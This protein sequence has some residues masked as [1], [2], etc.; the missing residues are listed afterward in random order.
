MNESLLNRILKDHKRRTRS[1]ALILCLSMIVSLG[2]FAGFHQTAIAKVYTRE[3]L[4]CPY[5]HEGAEPVAH[6]HND[7]CY[8]GETLVCTL[9]EREAHT[10]T[11]EC[12]AE[13]RVLVCTLEEN[14]GH[15]HSEACFDENGELTCQ[16]PEGEG[17]HV[18][19]DDC[20]T[21]ERVLTCD[22]PELPVHVHDAGCFRTEEITVDEPEDTAASEQAVSTVPEMPVS[23]PNADIETAEDWNRE[24]ENLEL[25]GNWARDL[26]LVAATQQG[27]GESPNNFE[28][29][30][31]DAGD[32]W[33]RHGYTRYGAW[34]GYPYAEWDAMFVSF[35]LRYAGIPA[36]NVPNNPTAAYMAESFSKGELFAGQDYV[37]AVGDL[38]FFDTADDE[39]T[40]ID[41]MGIV[42]HVDAE[43][44]TINTVEGD[45]TDTVA[46]FGYYLNDE[47][48]VGYGILPQNPNYVPNEEENTD[49]P[50]EEFDGFIFMTTDEEEETPAAEE[51]TAPAVSMPAQSWERTAGGIKVSVEAPEGAFPENTTIAVTPVNGNSLK[52]TVSDAVSG[53]VLE[54]Q[55]VDITFFDA[56]GREIEPAVPIRVVMTP[57]A[58]ENAEEKTSVVH[59]DVAQQTAELIEQAE[60]TEADNSEVVFDADAFTIYAIVYTYQVEYEYEVDGKTFTSSMPGAENMSLTQIV[61]GLGIVDETEIETFVSKIASIASSNEEVAV[62]NENNEIRVLKDGEA[63]IVI[64]MQDGAK[65]H[66][67]VRAEGETSA[68]NETATVSTV[69]E[70]YLPADAELKA[71]VVGGEQA[72]EA[73]KAIEGQDGNYQVFDIS[74]DNVEVD[75]YD[76][77]QVDLTLPAKILGSEFHLYHVHEGKAEELLLKK[78]SHTQDDGNELVESVSFV[79]DSFSYFVLSYTV[80][81]TFEI[82]G[83]T[84]SY[85][86]P[87]TTSATISDILANLGIEN[88]D[89]FTSKISAISF[90][91]P[92]L[93][94]VTPIVE[95]TT[96][97]W[98][99]N[100][101]FDIVFEETASSYEKASESELAAEDAR[102]ATVVT[103][104]N[105]VLTSTA[106]FDTDEVLTIIMM[107]G[108]AFTIHVTDALYSGLN[109]FITDAELT[110]NGQTYGKNDTWEV[111]PDTEYNLTLTFSEKGQRQLPSGGNT[112]MMKLP[113]G[114]TLPNGQ[115]GTFDIPFGLAGTLRG[116]TYEVRDGYLYVTFA[117]DPKN[118]LERSSN[119]HFEINLKAMFDEDATEIHFND[120][121]N[122]DVDVKN[123]GSVDVQKTGYYNAST[124]MMEYDITVTSTG[125]TQNIV[126][127][128]TIQGS[129][130]QYDADS[131][132]VSGIDNPPTP[133]TGENGFSVTIPK[134]TNGQVAHIHYTGT[135]DLDSLY[136]SGYKI[137]GVDGQNKVQY[138]KDNN[139]DKEITYEYTNTIN[140]SN[141]SKSNTKATTEDGKTTLEWTVKVNENPQASIVG[142]KITDKIGWGSKDIMSYVTEDGEDGKVPVSVIVKDENGN[143]VGTITDTAILNAGNDWTPASWTYTIPDLTDL[144]NSASGFT[145]DPSYTG[146]IP[147]AK[148]QKYTYEISYHTTVTQ[149]EQNQTVTNDS[150]N[151]HGG[152]ST[153]TGVV[154]GTNPNNPPQPGDEVITVTKTPTDVTQEYIEWKVVVNIP[155]GNYYSS[156]FYILDDL[157]WHYPDTGSGVTGGMVDTLD[158]SY[159]EN[160]FTK[161]VKVEGLKEGQESFSVSTSTSNDKYLTDENGNTLERQ[162]VKIQFYK[163]ATDQTDENKG[164]GQDEDRTLT[165]TIRTKNSAYWVE[166]GAKS[167]QLTWHDNNVNAMGYTANGRAQVT[168]P[169]IKK[170][171]QNANKPGYF[172]GSDDD[173]YFAYDVVISN[174][175]QFPIQ[176]TD[177][178][179]GRYLEFVGWNGLSELMVDSATGKVTD[180][181]NRYPGL[182]IKGGANTWDNES[183]GRINP[184]PYMP[185]YTA[186]TGSVQFTIPQLFKDENNNYYPYYH[187]RYYL[188]VRDAD[189]LTQAAIANQGKI[190]LGNTVAWGDIDDH[191]DITY[192]VP[193]IEKDGWFSNSAD[194]NANERSYQFLIDVNPDALTF[195]NN[196][197][198]VVDSHSDN[199]SVDYHT[200]V[201]YEIPA[202]ATVTKDEFRQVLQ[203]LAKQ[204]GGTVLE[205]W[206]QE[207]INAL[208]SKCHVNSID[209][210]KANGIGWDFSGSEG[211]FSGLDDATHY[212]ITYSALIVGT[213]NQSFYNEAN[214]D[215]YISTKTDS[216]WFDS[217]ATAG[218]DVYQIQLLK[219][220]K[221]N[222]AH[223]LAGA[224]FQLFM[225]DGSGNPIPMTYGD[226]KF[227][228]GEEVYE[229]IS[230]GSK[231][232]EGRENVVGQPITF[233]TDDNGYVL[234]KLNQTA[235]GAELEEGVHYYL[236]EIASPVGYKIDSSVEYWSFTL[237]QDPD[238][239][240]YGGRDAYGV[241]Q[242]IYFYY[243]DILKMSNTPVEN[244]DVDISVEKKWYDVDGNAITDTSKLANMKAEVQLCR[245][246]STGTSWSAW[247][248]IKVDGATITE[249]N[250]VKT[251]Q[252]VNSLDDLK[253]SWTNLPRSKTVDNV[254]TY[255][256][257][258]IEEI[259]ATD[260]N[261]TEQIER[262]DTTVTSKEST[263]ETTGDK[264]EYT[265][266]NFAVE[267][268]TK[269]LNIKKVWLDASG[270]TIDNPPNN[271]TFKLYRVISKT[272]FEFQPTAGGSE[273]FITENLP[274]GV[275]LVSDGDEP[276][277]YQMSN[278]A[279]GNGVTFSA[280]DYIKI[281]AENSSDVTYYAYYVKETAVDGYDSSSATTT[282][283]DT[284]TITLTNKKIPEERDTSLTIGK[285]WRW[286]DGTE[287][288]VAMDPP[289]NS[290]VTYQIYQVKSTTPFTDV[291]KV[292]SGGTLYDAKNSWGGY[293]W[294]WYHVDGQPGTYQLGV[295]NDWSSTTFNNL[296]AVRVNGNVATYYA[297]Y[298]EEIDLPENIEASYKIKDNGDGTYSVLMTNKKSPEQ[299]MVE[300]SKTWK[301]NGA[302]ANFAATG[303]PAKSW[304]DN[305][306]VKVELL[307]D[308]T[309]V[310][311]KVLYLTSD[312]TSD[313]FVG[314]PK[315]DENGNAY[316]Y[317]VRETVQMLKDGGTAI[318]DADWEETVTI[319]GKAISA[320]IAAT[321][322]GFGLTNDLKSPGKIIVEKSFAGEDVLTDEQKQS[323]TF[324]VT[325]PEGATGFP[326]TSALGGD[327][328]HFVF[329]DGKYTWTIENIDVA[330]EYTVT[331]S[332]AATTVESGG[333]TYTK[334]TTMRVDGKSVGTGETTSFTL[335][336]SDSKVEFINRYDKPYDGSG[337]IDV[338]K[339]WSSSFTDGDKTPAQISLYRKEVDSLPGTGGGDG[340]N[341]RI[342][343]NYS[344]WDQNSNTYKTIETSTS[345][346]A[347]EIVTVVVSQSSNYSDDFIIQSNSGN[348]G[349]ITDAKKV[350]GTYTLQ[351]Q[352]TDSTDNLNESSN[353]VYLASYSG[354]NSINNPSITATNSSSG[355]GGSTEPTQVY[356]DS[357]KTTVADITAD[358]GEF[359]QSA[360]VDSATSWTHHFGNLPIKTADGTKYYVYYVVEDG[361]IAYAA[362]YSESN[363]TV[364]IT[365]NSKPET[366]SLSVKKVWKNAAGQDISSTYTGEAQFELWQVAT[367][368]GSSA[369]PG[370]GDVVKIRSNDSSCIIPE[371][372]G[373]LGNNIELVFKVI[374]S[375]DADKNDL[376][377][378]N[379]IRIYAGY[380][381]Y[382]NYSGTYSQ[383][384]YKPNLIS[385]NGN[386][387]IIKYVIPTYPSDISFAPKSI[388]LKGFSWKGD[389]HEFYGTQDYAG[390]E[391]QETT[392]TTENTYQVFT[393]SNA[394][395]DWTKHFTNLPLKSADGKTTYSYYVKEIDVPSEWTVAYS[396]EDTE[397][398]GQSA[399]ASDGTIIATN[400]VPT[401]NTVSISAEKTWKD[402]QG[403]EGNENFTNH[404]SLQFTLYRKALEEDETAPTE[405]P[406]TVDEAT[407]AGYTLAVENIEG[408]SSV[409]KIAAGSATSQAENL[410]AAWADLPEKDPDGKTYSYLVIEGNVP[411]YT[412]KSVVKDGTD[413]SNV[414]YAFTNELDEEKIDLKLN[415]K[416]NINGTQITEGLD[417]TTKY[418]EVKYKVYQVTYT[419]AARTTLKD[420]TTAEGVEY[421]LPDG[422]GKLNNTNSWTETL[423]DLPKMKYTA[424][425]EDGVFT[426]EYY[427]YYVVEQPITKD[428]DDNEYVVSY[429]VGDGPILDASETDGHSTSLNM[430]LDETSVTITNGKYEVEINIL[431]TDPNQTPLTG[432]EFKLEMFTKS[433]ETVWLKWNEESEKYERFVPTGTTL[434]AI[435]A[436]AAENGASATFPVGSDGKAKIDK[437]PNGRYRFVETKAPD[438]YIIA[439]KESAIFTIAGGQINPEADN[440]A[441]YN[442]AGNIFIVPNNPGSALPQTGGIGTALFTALGGLMTATAG[443]IL[444]I[445]RKRKPA[446]G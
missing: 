109:E 357:A 328:T 206:E 346:M 144:I 87:G 412:I 347:G 404:P 411:H 188:K 426:A 231:F 248:A 322:N 331:E 390:G 397:H 201:A 9:P 107:N 373:T 78:K 420:G 179:D 289:Q 81:F 250:D 384:E 257:Y 251:L 155:K 91:A 84:F 398:T 220:V 446:E 353:V 375:N 1:L 202:G 326:K 300:V 418:P 277:Y 200:V 315:E 74:L 192:E 122:P 43:N 13:Q 90:T 255:Y 274:A 149:A 417:D 55:A 137:T 316:V 88:A 301:I 242:W 180:T 126:I 154:P 67:D 64:T 298:V 324:T 431:K 280:L 276:Q 352:I 282:T 256:E 208:C 158:E 385:E 267:E 400:T 396:P 80:D 51:A 354:T 110:I 432:A 215:G 108:E 27:R 279:Y 79:T 310:E 351:F 395:E 229:D 337:F 281:A 218:G 233:T 406:K 383:Y 33:V 388:E 196:N 153:G 372:N 35:C 177:T 120:R 371:V 342:T 164:I 138:G 288:G 355:G 186:D 445:R 113:D 133:T 263:D 259:P 163:S 156:D 283:S 205:T 226:T 362:T 336:T 53:E 111:Y 8:E 323:I 25:S 320:E 335:G 413:G 105:W 217:N 119:T 260:N 265:V 89:E 402:N 241:R 2:T 47:Q 102:L 271:I 86:M 197:L 145:K 295:N 10:H 95:N 157:P 318:N 291:T 334:T 225:D 238:G 160:G 258:K 442:K 312:K 135:L 360:V 296:P 139:P 71:E 173:V 182:Y 380:S 269:S 364:T 20:Y 401:P 118:L 183:T 161:G 146:E 39:I 216:R 15:Q 319:D 366:T 348:I 430:G 329:T 16:I 286:D 333:T 132:T 134:M 61:K 34:Y 213:G 313:N 178:F 303:E 273:F 76:G 391:Y 23:D 332:G 386:E 368:K 243:D 191:V 148:D 415:K 212:F 99:E 428:G 358:G 11:D 365:N 41:H 31:N 168:V 83:Q 344:Y 18:H 236:K 22:K 72:I 151:E 152:S 210:L 211:T 172:G 425:D 416:W 5:A 50:D 305:V 114:L 58:T 77:F 129:L 232:N 207:R 409:I 104:P 405:P 165:V 48:I 116:N 190:I 37:P 174:P 73:V 203:L 170:S 339:V 121:V 123:D 304:P 302:D 42:C 228:R 12:F 297:Y 115:S 234:I 204:Q 393:I 299:T 292:S 219:H 253:F 181:Y 159:N 308:G 103:A 419:N 49:I 294:N 193:V 444:T 106:P 52:D 381:S 359:Y 142:G 85:S 287:N 410:P 407:A 70:L 254:T 379:N 40:N 244:E 435:E 314:L 306:R 194:S 19:T 147:E 437:L 325:G 309:A 382:E 124:G 60:G 330:G 189:A 224:T 184:G 28:A 275:T 150:T 65:F 176:I 249:E 100:Q 44:G 82:D 378:S 54:V 141:I 29:V 227:T 46:T 284:T 57:A 340:T 240:N 422:T 403:A 429:Q 433:W 272:P 389:S 392:T 423:Q 239:V 166:S 285:E 338:E 394:D 169:S 369:M 356:V 209:Q 98:V 268:K 370:V 436:N 237:T 4:D 185:V 343:F 307:R 247:T 167:S 387:F 117:R 290:P 112:V 293:D 162:I 24:F 131:A 440:T 262:F 69:G 434:A 97:G 68:S 59:V 199:L 223:G 427:N 143:V 376:R 62:V 399:S 345:A 439:E 125:T 63:K 14:P 93:L 377:N 278:S 317:T 92:E 311:G 222:N 438:G 140:F 198:E 128:D 443:A 327:S 441:T 6:V 175:S 36:E 363:N 361:G 171:G 252:Y 187:F 3:V 246:S 367:T 96:I 235:H 7:D 56:E 321:A 38:I 261:T 414:T 264:I 101:V 21:I 30:L 350:G 26:V 75:N 245:R 230:D 424:I 341:Y 45:R 17:A 270:N 374:A 94:A 195:G 214:M 32:A 130:V 421:T 136:A 266:K 221:G 66:I 127:N 408:F 349:S